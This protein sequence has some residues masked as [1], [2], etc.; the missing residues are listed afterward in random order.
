MRLGV[1]GQ[2]LHQPGFLESFVLSRI[3]EAKAGTGVC[4]SYLVQ[5]IQD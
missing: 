5:C 1:A 2:N 4:S 3:S